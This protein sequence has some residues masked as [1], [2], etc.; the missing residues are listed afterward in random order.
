MNLKQKITR[1]VFMLKL[2]GGILKLGTAISAP[3]ILLNFKK[4]A[5]QNAPQYR[6][7]G[8]T[9]FKVSSVG[10]GATRTMEPA[11]F[12]ATLDRGMNFV[13]T[14]RNYFNGQNE[15][16]VGKV[17]KGMRDKIIVQS[18]VRVNLREQGE[19]RKT[20]RVSKRMTLML[21]NSLEESLR[22]LQ[23]DYLDILLLHG[24]EDI[25]LINHEALLNF[26]S[27]AKETGKIRACGFSAHS[28]QAQL[29][30]SVNET[31]FYDVLML[32]YNHK[33]SYIHS[34]YGH[35]GEWDQPA[36]EEQM[37]IAEKNG[38]GLVAMKT[39]SAGKYSPDNSLAPSFSDALRWVLQH[40]YIQ[41]MAVAMGNIDE[42]IEDSGAMS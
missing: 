22:A 4:S 24:A 32:A 15:V 9:G 28:N 2:T 17:I 38:I 27:Q 31:K 42:V 13:D 3:A 36:M 11:I 23:T 37:K 20:E 16:M 39:C 18:K 10:F 41:T 19:E 34:K 8:K 29:L 5:A 12:K 40:S 1:K 26:F 35:Y 21:N 6:I 7:L 30:K 33:G 25:D 14:G